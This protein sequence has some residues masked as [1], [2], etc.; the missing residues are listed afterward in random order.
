MR[1]SPWQAIG[2]LQ[3]ALDIPQLR[4]MGECHSVGSYAYSWHAAHTPSLFVQLK[5]VADGCDALAS[6]L[7]ERGGQAAQRGGTEK[8]NNMI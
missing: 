2:L 3:P 5:G 6:E 4:A 1:K 7:T 8:P